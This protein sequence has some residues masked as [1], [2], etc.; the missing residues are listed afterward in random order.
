MSEALSVTTGS[1]PAVQV[2]PDVL[3]YHYYQVLYRSSFVWSN[4]CGNELVLPDYF[5]VSK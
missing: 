5:S 1:L 2:I 4:S 3:R